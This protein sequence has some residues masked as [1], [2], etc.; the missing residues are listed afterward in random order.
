MTDAPG[1]QLAG[2]VLSDQCAQ[3][4]VWPIPVFDRRGSGHEA[5]PLGQGGRTERFG[6]GSI[7]EVTLGVE[8]I[9]DVGVVVGRAELLRH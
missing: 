9:V 4:S 1:L 8:V 2:M 6:G 7:D 5:A 3:V